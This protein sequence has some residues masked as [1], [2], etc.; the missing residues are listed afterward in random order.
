MF[1][2]FPPLFLTF[3]SSLHLAVTV[4]VILDFAPLIGARGVTNRLHELV[5]QSCW[6]CM[7]SLPSYFVVF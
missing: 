5:S 7:S 2:F 4:L 1:L 3:S 6:V